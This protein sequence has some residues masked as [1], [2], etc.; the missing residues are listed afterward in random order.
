L[1]SGEEAVGGM[2]SGEE[3]VSWRFSSSS[4]CAVSG[5]QAQLHTEPQLLT[6]GSST[7]GSR[8]SA[9]QQHS[10]GR[11]H[12]AHCPVPGSILSLPAGSSSPGA[13]VG[14]APKHYGQVS[15]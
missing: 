12:A 14:E 5:Q 10:Q 11:S 1:L 8:A 6:G 2:L 13:E 4:A 15:H 9:Q 3:A 7:R